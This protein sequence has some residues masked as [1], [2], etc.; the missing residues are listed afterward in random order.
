MTSDFLTRMAASSNRRLEEARA[1]CDEG[2]LRNMAE[3]RPPSAPLKLSDRGFDLIAE[4]KR[5][6]PSMGVLSDDTLSPA[7]Q[8][9][10]YA[11][12]GVA[13]IS[14]LTEPDQFSGEIAHLEQVAAALPR[15]PAMRKDFLVSPYQVIEAR[16]AGA[17]GVLLIAA[18]LSDS[19]LREMLQV[20]LELGMFALV[21]AFDASDLQ[22]CLPVMDAVGAGG[23]S[24]SN[25][26][27]EGH[28]RM[29]IG[30]NCRDLRSLD[31]DFARF[32]ALAKLLPAALPWVAESGVQSAAEAREV[33][34]LG[35]SFAL[36]GTALMRADD[37]SATAAAML[38]AGR[39][40]R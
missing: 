11:E 27:R 34:E 2:Q 3:S 16:A 8:A 38:A 1:R 4:V 28:C 5:R 23:T 14:V 19:E 6:S 29:L 7:Q 15:L 22:R 17:G 40:A 32:E 10:R 13:A 39:D 37:P 18:M 9:T 35:Y 33:A 12:A 36:V 26:E 21:E 24:D 20:T 25:S 30:V 31:V